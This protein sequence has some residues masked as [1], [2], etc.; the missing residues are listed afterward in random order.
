MSISSPIELAA[1]QI[2][3]ADRPPAST[4]GSSGRCD[5]SS[6]TMNAPPV[7]PGLLFAA[8]ALSANHA[9]RAVGRV[10]EQFAESWREVDLAE[11]G[12]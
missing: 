11:M 10:P 6:I 4:G 9:S 2:T 8:T 5:N 3:S 12:Y 1:G 7:N